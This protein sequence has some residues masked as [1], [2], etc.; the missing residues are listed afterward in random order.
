MSTLTAVPHNKPFSF[1]GLVRETRA[2]RR[3][4]QMRFVILPVT[5][6]M[7]LGTQNS[8]SNAWLSSP[9]F[10]KPPSLSALKK[11]V[12]CSLILLAPECV[13]QEPPLSF[14]EAAQLGTLKDA[15]CFTKL[16]Q[17]PCKHQFRALDF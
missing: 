11:H 3:K 5:E 16:W 1:L 9:V 8:V 13:C 12:P 4:E 10:L 7:A 2:V 14:R 17:M 15:F 6:P